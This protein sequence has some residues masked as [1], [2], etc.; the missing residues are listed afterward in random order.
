M[1]EQITPIRK[2][3]NVYDPQATAD[4]K[5]NAI[6]Q[7]LQM[8]L[9]MGQKNPIRVDMRDVDA[10]RETAARYVKACADANI[11]PNIE[12]LC[13]Q[14]GISRRWFY[15]YLD[16]HPDTQTA[17]LL[18]RIRTEWASA[19]IAL[20]ERGVLDSTMVIFLS[21]NSS[22]GFSNEHRLVVE[23]PSAPLEAVDSDAARSRIVEALPCDD[24]L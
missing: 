1:S 3:K 16:E 4:V 21:L 17:I 7:V 2:G 13:A 24:E 10:V 14:L 9:R 12:G 19:R 23:P 6:A 15:K 5:S 11:M 20:A 8:Q 18:D 22:L